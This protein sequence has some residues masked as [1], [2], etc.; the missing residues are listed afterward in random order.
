[1]NFSVLMSIYCQENSKYFHC[2]MMSIWDEQTIKPDEIILVKDGPLTEALDTAINYWK[3]KIG[4]IFKVIPLQINTGLGNALNIG[5]KHCSYDLIARMDT[6]DI[7]LPNRFEKQ[8]EVFKNNNIDVCSAWI[9]EFENDENKIISYR[10]TP[11]FH[12]DIVKYGKTRSPIN[13][14]PVM[15]RKSAVLSAGGYKHMLWMEDYYLWIRMIINGAKTYNIQEP[16]AKIRAGESQLLRRSGLKYL[17]SEIKLHIE[18]YKI[19]FISI[20]RL[21]INIFIRFFVRL[22]PKKVLQVTYKILR[23]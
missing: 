13:H 17:V 1:M 5:M 23:K 15:F 20:F 22:M 12:N 7:S 18:L 19:R 11:E 6:D 16:L 3:E 9:A 2:A 14:I 21:F 4:T 8:L 10:K